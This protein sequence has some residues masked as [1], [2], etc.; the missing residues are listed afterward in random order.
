MYCSETSAAPV[1]D[2][3]LVFASYY[4]LQLPGKRLRAVLP[5]SGILFQRQAMRKETK[6]RNVPNAADF[7]RRSQFRSSL[8]EAP[9]A[10]QAA[11]KDKRAHEGRFKK[12]S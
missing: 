11:A 5:S 10:I 2:I 1:R 4:V 6:L 3:S 7:E 8:P 12:R 9:I